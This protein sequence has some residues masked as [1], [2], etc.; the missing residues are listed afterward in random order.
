MSNPNKNMPDFAELIKDKFTM[1]KD[2]A[3][4]ETSSTA[5]RA[6]SAGDKFYYNNLLQKA[7]TDIAQGDTLTLN[8]NYKNADPVTTTIQNLST[9]VTSLKETLTNLGLTIVDGKVCQ[10][11][12]E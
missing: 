3:P 12:N 6:Y 2:I 1:R 8:T 7:T 10:T 5:S 9:Q 4:V 11:Y